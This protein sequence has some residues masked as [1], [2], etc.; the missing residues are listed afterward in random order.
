MLGEEKGSR[1]GWRERALWHQAV[2]PTTG[3]LVP[4]TPQPLCVCCSI[5]AGTE[6]LW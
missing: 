3:S 2:L 4:V 5:K 6:S 1:A